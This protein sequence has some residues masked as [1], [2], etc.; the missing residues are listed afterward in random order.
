[1]AAKPTI[2]QLTEKIGELELQ[3]E[4]LTSETGVAE[5]MAEKDAK[6]AELSAKVEELENSVAELSSVNESL[7][8]D[9]ASVPSVGTFKHEGAEYSLIAPKF[10]MDGNLV[11]AESLKGNSDLIAR[12]VELKFLVEIK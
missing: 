8:Q 9:N 3:I 11:N 12:A 2:A 4:K 6:I 7:S 1:M 10:H 5:V